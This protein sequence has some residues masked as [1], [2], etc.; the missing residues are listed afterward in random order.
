M[1]GA[2][3]VRG[4]NEFESTFVDMANQRMDAVVIFDDSI[5]VL[6]SAELARLSVKSHLPP[7][8]P[9][10]LGERCTATGPRQRRQAAGDCRVMERYHSAQGRRRGQCRTSCPYGSTADRLARRDLQLP[11]DGRFRTHLRQ[12]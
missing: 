4:P 5:L 1:E 8:W 9:L 12:C 2:F 10:L 6:N 7:R 3:Y 11:G